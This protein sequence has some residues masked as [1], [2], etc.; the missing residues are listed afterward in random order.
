[1]AHIHVENETGLFLTGK[2]IFPEKSLMLY[3]RPI[4]SHTLEDFEVASGE[5]EA[6]NDGWLTGQIRKN[7]GG[8]LYSRQSYPGDIVL[9]FDAMA[10]P[11]C[12]NDLNFVWKASGWDYARPGMTREKALSAVW[13]AGGS[14]GPAL[15]NIPLVFLLWRRGSV[16]WRPEGSSTSRRAAWK[17]MHLFLQTVVWW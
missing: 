7:G 14:T 6:S 11:P 3:D 12:D 16:R 2:R 5:W 17:I 8:I 10:V 4:D 13:V 9:E 15:R 1:M